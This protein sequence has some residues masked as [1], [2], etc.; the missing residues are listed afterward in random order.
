LEWRDIRPAL[1]TQQLVL[2][3]L[4][5]VWRERRADG[6]Q[7]RNRKSAIEGNGGR[8]LPPDGDRGDTVVVF[9]S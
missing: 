5:L 8:V 7:I 2:R 1:A 3:E 4:L 9:Q 6:I